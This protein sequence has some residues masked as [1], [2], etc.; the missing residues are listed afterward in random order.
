MCMCIYVCIYIYIYIY[1]ERERERERERETVFKQL[2]NTDFFTLD[3][4]G[5]FLLVRTIWFG[6]TGSENNIEAPVR[7]QFSSPGPA[8]LS[9][10]P[11]LCYDPYGMHL[12]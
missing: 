11:D 4:L 6:T 8:P 3:A 10:G 1:I 5:S 12:F 2:L 9:P 7:P